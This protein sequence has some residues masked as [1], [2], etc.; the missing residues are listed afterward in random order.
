MCLHFF[1]REVHQI[2]WL[3][4]YTALD[5]IYRTLDS[6]LTFFGQ[7][8]DTDNKALGL[9]KRLGEDFFVQMT[10][11]M[12]D[13]LQPV[14]KLSLYFQRKDVDIGTVQVFCSSYFKINNNSDNLINQ[15]EIKTRTS[16][17]TFCLQLL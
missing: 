12:M 11:T 14:M 6:L 10:Y 2:R 9:K 3:S 1:S 13:V 7:S 15:V 5:A 16:I 4:F 17:V 8:P